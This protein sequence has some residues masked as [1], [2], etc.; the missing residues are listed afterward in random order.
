MIELLLIVLCCWQLYKLAEHR[1]LSG[2]KWIGR[3]I[4]GYFLFGIALSFWLI[5]EY[6]TETMKNF[7]TAKEKLTPWLPYTLLFLV[8]W[9][10][11]IRSR[12]MKYEQPNDDQ[13][14]DNYPAP[15]P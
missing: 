2:W 13:T 3:F 8:V 5:F 12:L 4:S 6:G 9:F 7:D 11:F 1:Q 15:E 10:V 14:D